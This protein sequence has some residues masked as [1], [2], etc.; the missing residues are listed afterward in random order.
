MCPGGWQ[1]RT[2]TLPKG[3]Q[4]AAAGLGRSKTPAWRA[5][6]SS[7]GPRWQCLQLRALGL[8]RTEST[9]GYRAGKEGA[10]EQETRG[11]FRQ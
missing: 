9:G 2:P 5:G 11:G 10:L 6:S 3:E 1:D 4:S 8:G 7:L